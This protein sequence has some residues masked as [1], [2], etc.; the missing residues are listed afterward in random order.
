MSGRSR[1]TRPRSLVSSSFSAA[2]CV[3]PSC[4]TCATSGGRRRIKERRIDDAKLAA[5]EAASAADR[6][7]AAID[8]LAE[9]TADADMA[10]P[11]VL[12]EAELDTGSLEAADTPAAPA[13][14]EAPPDGDAEER[15]GA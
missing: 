3:A 13:E 14:Q 2:G 12:D 7:A 10:G 9:E 5:M 11:G 1:C 6:E 15:A 4:I 8:D